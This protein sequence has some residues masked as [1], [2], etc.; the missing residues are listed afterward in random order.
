M[1]SDELAPCPSMM[2]RRV[3]ATAAALRRGLPRRQAQASAADRSKQRIGKSS[4]RSSGMRV[5]ASVVRG[6]VDRA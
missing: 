3:G 1:S 2:A 4:R 5:M 6:W